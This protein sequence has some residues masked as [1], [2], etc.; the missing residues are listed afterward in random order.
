MFD[1]IVVG[2]GPAGLNAA[3]TLGRQRRRVLV[4]DSGTYRNEPAEEMHMFLSRDGF[5]PAELRR[6]GREELSRYS[7]VEIREDLV[8]AVTGAADDFTVEL[9]GGSS[10]HARR[11]LL[12]SGQAD[13]LP[14]VEGVAEQFG[15][16]VYHCP[17]CHGFETAG[18]PL[19]VLGGDFSHAMLALYVADRFSDDVVLCANG[20]LEVSEELRAALADHKIEVREE[21]VTRVDGVQDALTVH[22][23]DGAPLERGAVFHR[24]VSRQRSD[25]AASLGCELLPDGCVRVNAMQQTTVAGV[26]AAG[27]TARLAELVGPTPFV[28]TAAADGAKAAIWL[29]QDLFRSSVNVPI[30]G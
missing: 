16:G 10:E 22:F 29:E 14:E 8:V 25:L 15:R 13:V 20:P 18:K 3:L 19:A 4:V 28:I 6:L 9:A 24:P 5:P 21:P 7:T 23:A 26:Y 2:G 27:D 11:L 17:F 12:A 30:P 1:V